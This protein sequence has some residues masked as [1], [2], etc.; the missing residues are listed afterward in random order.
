MPSQFPIRALTTLLAVIVLLAIKP[1]PVF[2]EAPMLCETNVGVP[3]QLFYRYSGMVYAPVA[4]EKIRIVGEPFRYQIENKDG[5]SVFVHASVPHDPDDAETNLGLAENESSVEFMQDNGRVAYQCRVQF[6]HLD[7]IMH[8]VAALRSGDCNM[9]Q[10]AG[11]PQLTDGHSQVWALQEDFEEIRVTPPD[12]V[13]VT[14]LSARSFY[15]LPR[16]PGLV[17]V[18]VVRSVFDKE[19]ATSLCPFTVVTRQIA[20][21]VN[22]LK[23]QEICKDANGLPLRLSVGQST[24]FPLSF[25]EEHEFATSAPTILDA[26]RFDPVRNTMTIMGLAPGTSSLTVITVDGLQAKGCVVK[27]E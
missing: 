1:A 15:L 6:V 26:S 25:D 5:L 16:R 3:G 11:L 17:V 10:M 13:N 22:G 18:E 4:F 8:E 12:I 20:L 7:P 19:R 2:A 14:R 21:G 24:E 23:D 27:V 9:T